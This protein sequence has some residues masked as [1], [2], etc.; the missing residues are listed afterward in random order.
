VKN[1]LLGFSFLNSS[2][3][4]QDL[5]A[6]A[7]TPRL[8][9]RV[10]SKA[11]TALRKGHPWLFSDSIQHQSRE[12][13]AGEFAVIYDKK[14]C[15]LGIGLF[16]PDSPIRVR[17][18]HVGKPRTLDGSWW[19]EHWQQTLSKRSEM[20]DSQT[21]GFR[22][23]N[24]ESD[25][26]PGLILDRY[27]DT[28][29]LKIY[30]AAWLPHLNQILECLS[31]QI[32]CRRTVLRLSRNTQSKSREFADGQIV[33][34]DPPEGCVI[35]Q[36]S[37]LRFEADVLRGQ[38]TGFFLDQRENRKM[39]ESLA[40]GRDVL[41]LFSFSG[42]FSVY[43]ARGGAR[44]VTDVDISAHALAS[45][46]RNFALNHTLLNGKNFHYRQKQADVFEWLK[47]D[48]EERFDLIIV[49]PP[50]LAKREVDR[51]EA[52]QA[53]GRLI[54][55]SIHLLRKGGILVAA[56]CSA[57]VSSLEFFDAVL[58]SVRKSNRSFKEFERKGHP[59]DHPAIIPEAQYL[60]CIYLEF[61][62]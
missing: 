55:R 38:K 47:E 29:V 36:E 26:W 61:S 21:T 8:K 2:R 51:E 1:S 17:M 43:A 45:A 41:N 27:D 50:S 10:S 37:G 49:D 40:S 39:V 54:K 7:K 11:E 19:Q 42:G 14:D 9:L 28:L 5:N 18:L 58:E 22:Y 20:F 35:F 48:R 31:L 25:G 32:P 13:G 62:S 56:S 34:G 44:S 60:K 33:R 57:H 52:I 16:D 4:H 23:C 15:F 3:I 46:E 53:Y 12:A 6:S 30:S 59:A 24:G